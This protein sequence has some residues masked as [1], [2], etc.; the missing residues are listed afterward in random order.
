MYIFAKELL[1]LPE[2]NR[3]A[4]LVAGHG[5]LDNR[6]EHIT[7][8]EA[9]DFPNWVTGNEFVLSTLYS[10]KDD[11]A[12]QVGLVE[13]LSARG[14]AAL[15]VK[16]NR[17]IGELPERMLAEANLHNLPLF[18][19]NTESKFRELIRAVSMEII[20][21][22]AKILLEVDQF[23]DDM[24]G[25]ALR[26]CDIIE[27]S[28]SL[29][30]RVGAAC[31][32]V[33]RSGMCLASSPDLDAVLR[34]EALKVLPKEDGTTGRYPPISTPYGLLHFYPCVA[35]TEPLGY[36]VVV[37]D[38][39]LD[40]RDLFMVKKAAYAI[41]IRLLEDQLRVEARQE[42]IT[43]FVDDVLYKSVEDPAPVRERAGLFGWNIDDVSL[44]VIAREET[45]RS[46]KD[47]TGWR[48]FLECL[49][50]VQRYFP[51][52]L[53]ATKPNEIITFISF[54]RSSRFLRLGAL[55]KAFEDILN[56]SQIPPGVSLSVGIGSKTD[57]VAGLS[58]SYTDAKK[59]LSLGRLLHPGEGVLDYED[60]LA[61][62][63]VSRSAGSK[64]A[65]LLCQKLLDPLR[66]HDQRYNSNL[67]ESVQ[68]VVSSGTVEAAAERLHVHPNSLRYRLQK[69]AELTGV[70]PASA[71][72]R[73]MYTIALILDEL[74]GQQ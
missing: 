60:F 2:F 67:I 44:V 9:P 39:V 48:Y 33:T 54:P 59:V 55:K 27:L 8:M 21:R 46:G 23:H 25:A 12:A 3:G 34:E 4:K 37:K 26:G 68:C 43:S 18:A 73:V 22:Q 10:I 29:A 36:L 50:G 16:I 63:V 40:E 6:I 56:E 38:T 35:R 45:S 72:G 64:E 15:G 49:K 13:K 14:V 53:S 65:G 32:V 24:L 47:R 20:N 7:V 5:G 69:T 74:H 42:S 17:F 52:S 61:E 31:L 57:R 71:K 66:D 28:R 62:L 58:Y 70:N 30:L 11:V 1:E 19:V 41:A 51:N